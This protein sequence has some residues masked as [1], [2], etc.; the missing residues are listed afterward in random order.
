MIHFPVNTFRFV[1]PKIFGLPIRDYLGR[2]KKD[3]ELATSNQ[4]QPLIHLGQLE[5]PALKLPQELMK[6]REMIYD[7]NLLA[8][9]RDQ[10]TRITNIYHLFD[11]I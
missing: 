9:A 8:V 10:R 7:M 2:S 1:T 4:L 5:I 3:G 11:L 6:A